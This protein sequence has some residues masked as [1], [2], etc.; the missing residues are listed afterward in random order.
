[1]NMY[2]FLHPVNPV[3]LCEFFFSMLLL[4]FAKIIKTGITANSPFQ[5]TTSIVELDGVF[6]FTEHVLDPYSFNIEHTYIDRE[7]KC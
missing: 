7:M 4:I 3:Y 2:T 5:T 6:V 1:M